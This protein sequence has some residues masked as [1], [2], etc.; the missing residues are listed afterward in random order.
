MKDF[1]ER[2]QDWYQI[3]CN[4][5]LEASPLF[6]FKVIQPFPNMHAASSVFWPLLL[7]HRIMQLL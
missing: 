6:D 7:T 5:E 3:H 4:G 2:I 1:L